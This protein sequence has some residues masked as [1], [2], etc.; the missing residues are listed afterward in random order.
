M[1][2]KG[3]ISKNSGGCIAHIF[4]ALIHK[5][6]GNLVCLE[7]ESEELPILLLTFG[8][9]WLLTRRTG[10]NKFRLRNCGIIPRLSPPMQLIILQQQSHIVCFLLLYNHFSS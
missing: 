3:E 8:C 1:E 4:E 9:V 7:Y 10:T 5:S 2:E 6:W